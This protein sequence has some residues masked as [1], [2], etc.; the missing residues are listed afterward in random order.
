MH[1]YIA[2]IWILAASYP[3]FATLVLFSAQ[4]E[5]MQKLWLSATILLLLYVSPQ[6][7][8]RVRYLTAPAFYFCLLIGVLVLLRLI[9]MPFFD[10]NWALQMPTILHLA[11]VLCFMVVGQ[12][13]HGFRLDLTPDHLYRAVNWRAL[14]VALKCA[15]G[16]ILLC[17]TV[18][19]TL[20]LQ[21]QMPDKAADQYMAHQ[22][23]INMV[24]N[25]L[26]VVLLLDLLRLRSPAGATAAESD[27]PRV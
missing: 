4:A 23:S 22:F 21:Q 6:V 18:L 2:L 1:R 11:F 17:A 19:L 24:L 26:F 25:Q 20:I 5:L 14:S 3:L 16:F 15:A 9:C 7:L 8:G 13:G 27:E 12:S 10:Q